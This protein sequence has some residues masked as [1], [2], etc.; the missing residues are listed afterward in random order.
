MQGCKCLTRKAGQADAAQQ[1]GDRSGCHSGIMM[2]VKLLHH[3]MYFITNSLL[4]LRRAKVSLALAA[5][6]HEAINS[7]NYQ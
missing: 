1:L 7:K 4:A 5:V 2:L 6:T 3:S